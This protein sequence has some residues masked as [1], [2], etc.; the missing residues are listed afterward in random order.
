MVL[1]LCQMTPGAPA[2]GLELPTVRQL[3][4]PSP[5]P[6]AALC[7]WRCRNINLLPITYACRPRLRTR[8]TLSGKS[9]LEETLGLRRTGFSP[10]LALLMST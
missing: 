3:T 9:W 4:Y 1:R 5:S 2:Y 6:R 8:L 10:V 7:A